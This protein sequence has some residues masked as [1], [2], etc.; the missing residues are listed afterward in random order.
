MAKKRAKYSYLHS[1]GDISVS[2][3]DDSFYIIKVTKVS[4]LISS[5]RQRYRNALL[6]RIRFYSFYFTPKNK[7]YGW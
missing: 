2:S 1:S 6:L 5:D 3:G 7:K 4:N